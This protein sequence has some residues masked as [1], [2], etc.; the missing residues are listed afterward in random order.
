MMLE[1]CWHAR[2]GFLRKIQLDRK[3]YYPALGA[4]QLVFRLLDFHL[5][6]GFTCLV[7]L[8]VLQRFLIEFQIC[9]VVKSVCGQMLT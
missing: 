7:R 1:C 4:F 3:F 5:Q 6:L 8:H 9:S 2:A